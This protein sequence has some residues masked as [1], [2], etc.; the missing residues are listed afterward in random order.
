MMISSGAMVLIKLSRVNVHKIMIRFII[1]ISMGWIRNTVA[2]NIR[3]VLAAVIPSR[4]ALI[5]RYCFRLSQN[6]IKK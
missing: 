5:T 6:R 2:V 3:P 1:F 4:E